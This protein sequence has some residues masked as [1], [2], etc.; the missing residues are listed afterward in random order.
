ML[1][2][3]PMPPTATLNDIRKQIDEIDDQIHNLLMCRADLVMDIAAEKKK[4][5]VQIIQP[6]R[7][8]R[9][10]RRLIMRHKGLLQKQAVIQIWR[11]LV[12]SVCL[13]QKDMQAAVWQPES[14]LSNQ[15]LEWLPRESVYSMAR[16]YFGSLFPLNIECDAKALLDN[17]KNGK[18]DFG[19][20]PFDDSLHDLRTF[21]T[22]AES[23]WPSFIDFRR[24]QA[25][26]LSITQKLPITTSSG[27]SCRTPQA[28][29]ISMAEFQ[30]SGSDN[31]ILVYDQSHANIHWLS[32][33]EI[34]RIMIGV[35]FSVPEIYLMTN[36]LII[37]V[38]GFIESNDQ[39]LISLNKQGLI[40]DILGGYPTPL[41]LG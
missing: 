4:S 15:S 25:T 19:I 29:L 32:P 13:L 41:D 33:S 16:D 23:W 36:S 30:A 5:G 8:I 38:S 26:K 17:I 20:F 34:S 31:T 1:D 27:K 11:E 9:T 35:G 40:L 22:S 6:A 21:A 28:F 37:I 24:N 18:Y 14:C 2:S 3:N 7:E 39:R 12:G 10:L